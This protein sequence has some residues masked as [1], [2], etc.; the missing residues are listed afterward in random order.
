MQIKS[1]RSAFWLKQL[2]AI[3]LAG[4]ADLVLWSDRVGSTLGLL[5]AGI[6]IAA[7][8]VRPPAR[9]DRRALLALVAAALLA[10]AAFDHPTLLAAAMFAIAI[11]LA[12]LSK[13]A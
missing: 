7:L 6:L 13:R 8:T 11:G 10:A 9:G 4:L 3:L 1:V 2:L 12:V 5:G